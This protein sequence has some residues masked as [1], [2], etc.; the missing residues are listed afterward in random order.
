MEITEHS[1]GH[2]NYTC[3]YDP[4]AEQSHWKWAV[5]ENE[6]FE[7]L[8]KC[9]TFCSEDPPEAIEGKMKRMWNGERWRGSFPAYSC[10]TDLAFELPGFKNKHKIKMDCDYDNVTDSNTWLYTYHDVRST[11]LPQCVPIC[12][13][14]PI[15]VEGV[16]NRTWTDKDWSNGSIA[17]YVCS[18]NV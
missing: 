10:E 1:L 6:W 11:E 8:P 3:I 12:P 18:G 9:D 14:E 15:L 4:E 5:D 13:E 17:T 2:I 16:V 7:E